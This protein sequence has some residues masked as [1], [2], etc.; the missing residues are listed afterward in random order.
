MPQHINLTV[1][2]RLTRTAD[3]CGTLGRGSLGGSGFRSLRIPVL[4][5]QCLAVVCASAEDLPLLQSGSLICL[6]P[7]CWTFGL[8]A[9]S[10]FGS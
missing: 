6:M 9:I 5:S 7:A 10:T 4:V 1:R 8:S 3:F 2:R